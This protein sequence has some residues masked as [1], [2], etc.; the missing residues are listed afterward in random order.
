MYLENLQKCFAGLRVLSFLHIQDVVKC[1]Y[2]KSLLT[3][4]AFLYDTCLALE[5]PHDHEV[6][7]RNQ[8]VEIILATLSSSSKPILLPRSDKVVPV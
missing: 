2:D 6:V 1:D 5:S 4:L 3:D 8:N 7:E